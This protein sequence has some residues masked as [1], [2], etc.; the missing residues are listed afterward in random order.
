MGT[1]E[2]N[3]NDRAEEQDLAVEPCRGGV[4]IKLFLVS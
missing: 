2:G 3:V 4:G 1:W